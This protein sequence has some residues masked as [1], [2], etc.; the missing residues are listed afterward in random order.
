MTATLFPPRKL[1]RV[2]VA[3]PA[4]AF[5]DSLRMSE[6]KR[7]AASQ[8]ATMSTDDIAALP[9]GQ[10]VEEDAVCLL[11]YPDSLAA[12]ALKVLAAWSF[13]QTQ[14][15]TWVKTGKY[16]PPIDVRNVPD[17][18][19][20]GQ[21]GMGRLARN[22][23]EHLFVG[24]RGSPYQHLKAKN[25]RSVFFAPWPERHSGKP[26]KIQDAID[27]M[28]PTGHRV[29]LFARRHRPGWTTWGLEAPAT[30]GL[31]IRDVLA[32]ALLQREAR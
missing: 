21:L 28:L 29:E 30:L 1:Y 17:D 6:V 13:R 22:N 12:D 18:V 25:V 8:Y 19:D 4:W 24:V 32:G 7:G 14:Q 9:V 31:D 11:W 5:G 23:A 27:R 20:L 26:E 10:I 15:W 16:Q 2:V 3:D